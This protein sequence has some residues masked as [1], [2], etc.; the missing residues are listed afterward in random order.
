MKTLI[1]LSYYARRPKI[2]PVILALLLLFRSHFAY[3]QCTAAPITAAAC[4]GGN[5]AASDGLSINTGTTYWVNS[6]AVFSALTL[7][8]GTLRICG[9]LIVSTF[10]V[11]NSGGNLI[12][13][14]GGSLTVG[15]M[16]SINGGLTFINRGSFTN[17]SGFSVQNTNHI[18]NEL[19]TSVMSI[20]GTVTFPSSST[21]FVNRGTLNFSSLSYSAGTG[22]FCL[23]DGS[24]TSIGTLDNEATNSFTYSGGGFPACINIS[25]KATLGHDLAS[26]SKIHVCKGGAATVS[27][28]ATTNPG[29]GWG[30]AILTNNCSSCATV[31]DLSI[32]NFTAITTTSGIEIKW[33]ANTDALAGGLF[34][35]E[36]STDGSSFQTIAV[37]TPIY[38][39]SAYK[40]DDDATATAPV[41]Y[42][43]VKALSSAGASLY[44]PI[45]A[46]RSG[47][48]TGQLNI[49]PNPARPGGTINI[50]LQVGSGGI[51][52]LSL[53]DIAGRVLLT[54][55]ANLVKGPNTLTWDPGS[56][57]PK[58]YIIRV[59]LPDGT[60]LYNRLSVLSP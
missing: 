14:S 24:I 43:R 44:S 40:A 5:G 55:P 10:S 58:I 59:A 9:H 52:R 54:K 33:E 45:V 26:S 12:I 60:C 41:Q 2:L 1:H 17:T 51:G 50:A 7:N 22:S 48:M 39:Q 42:Y 32:D 20:S 11:G 31:L 8:G 37:V 29:G 34:Y 21:T 53:I 38:G 28:G 3:S 19:S 46:V 15:T 25:V 30:S 13:E 47:S 16:S 4:G 27:G 18:Y 49:F 56:L 36:R 23:Q 57:I 35:V 6:S